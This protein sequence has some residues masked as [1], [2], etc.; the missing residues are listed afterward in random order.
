MTELRLPRPDD[1]HTLRR[2]ADAGRQVANIDFVTIT[3][4]TGAFE[5]VAQFPDIPGEVI[6]AQ[7]AQRLGCQLQWSSG[8]NLQQ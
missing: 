6:V 5:Y 3:E 1:R 8:A 7:P 4:Q 2:S